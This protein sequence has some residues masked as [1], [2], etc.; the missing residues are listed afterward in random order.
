MSLVYFH[1]ALISTAILFSFGMG[2]WGIERY[3][4]QRQILDLLTGIG[5]FIV[6]FLFTFYLLWFLKKKKQIW[7]NQEN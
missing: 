7:K 2:I 3:L 5:S 1:I 6:S 4:S